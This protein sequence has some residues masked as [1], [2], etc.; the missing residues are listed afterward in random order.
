MKPSLLDQYN[1]KTLSGQLTKE[2]SEELYRDIKK[3]ATD[4][5]QVL[6][7]E[8]KRV[9]SIFSFDFETN[10]RIVRNLVPFVLKADIRKFDEW[11]TDVQVK[12]QHSDEISKRYN[13]L[14]FSHSKSTE[15]FLVTKPFSELKWESKSYTGWYILNQLLKIDPKEKTELFMFYLYLRHNPE[16]MVLLKQAWAFQEFDI[17]VKKAKKNI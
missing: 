11:I 14:V 4:G 8:D 1:N 10:S 12:I 2:M 16:E 6:E 13:G 17:F 5:I 7:M 9:N 3:L 15:T